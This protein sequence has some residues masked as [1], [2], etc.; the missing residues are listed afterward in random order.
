MSDIGKEIYEARQRKIDEAVRKCKQLSSTFLNIMANPTSPVNKYIAEQLQKSPDK[1]VIIEPKNV[2]SDFGAL[3]KQLDDCNIRPSL[4]ELNKSS[5]YVE[6]NALEEC[7]YYEI[8]GAWEEDDC[9]DK[10]GFSVKLKQL[11][12]KL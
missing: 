11:I 6:Y 9:S 5:R 12:I 3:L 1:E 10:P 7:E 4:K 8:D 2:S